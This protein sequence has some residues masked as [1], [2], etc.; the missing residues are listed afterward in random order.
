VLLNPN[1]HV[2]Q[3]SQS[4]QTGMGDKEPSAINSSD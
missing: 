2:V 4:Y 1:I 3:V